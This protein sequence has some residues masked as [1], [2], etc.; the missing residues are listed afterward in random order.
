MNK[1]IM[2]LL[3]SIEYHE[4]MLDFDTAKLY[5]EMLEEELKKYRR[6]KSEAHHRRF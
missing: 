5:E 2:D 6:K 1:K 3:K 4:N